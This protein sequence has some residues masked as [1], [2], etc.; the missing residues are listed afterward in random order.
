MHPD[1]E[2]FSIEVPVNDSEAMKKFQIA[3]D[4]WQEA[5]NEHIC[6]IASELRISHDCALDVVYL[7]TR[8]R[9]SEENEAELIRLHS[10]GQAPNI[11]EWPK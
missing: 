7:R 1:N 4:E 3:E 5:M 8:S 11:M 6:E 9:W 2:V 10:I